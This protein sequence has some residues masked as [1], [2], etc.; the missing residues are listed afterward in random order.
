VSLLRDARFRRLLAG[1]SLSTFGD[2]ALYLTLGMWAKDL[3]GSNSAAGGVFLALGVPSLFAPLTGHVADR[4]RRRPLMLVTNAVMAVIVLSLL[5]VRSGHQLWII[6][7][8]AFCYGIAFGVLG[9]AGAGL[10]KVMLAGDD[11]AGA[12]AMLQTA[13]QGLRI[14]SPLAG[15]ALYAAF[16]GGA[17]ALLDVATFAAAIIALAGLR[18]DE[19]APESG[20]EPFLR[21][22]TAGLRHIWAVP[23]LRQTTMATACAFCVLG[24]GETVIFAVISSGLHRSTAFFG[25]TNSVQG[26]G[27]ILAG[28]T[29]AFLLRRA[30]EGRTVGLSLACFAAAALCYRIPAVPS[31]LAGAALDGVGSVWLAVGVMTAAQRYSPL[32]LQGRVSAAV[33]MAITGPQTISI[34]AGTILIAIV[35]YRVLLIAMAVLTGGCALVLLARPAQSMVSSSD[36]AVLGTKN[37]SA[38]VRTRIPADSQ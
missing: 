10:G 22:V 26:A 33:S 5:A 34:A 19:P 11:L 36:R 13:T 31:V 32:A 24:L 28:L 1:Q 7:L 38:Q 18:V 20:G 8:V 16:G 9:A 27:S 2:T 12:N 4:F 21:Q 29:V 17:V 35:D 14:V 6:Y 30:G 37:A 23:V 3:T 25:V 15:S